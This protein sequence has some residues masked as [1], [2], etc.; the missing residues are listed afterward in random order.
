MKVYWHQRS[1]LAVLSKLIAVTA[2]APNVGMP[3]AD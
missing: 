3:L 1:K 2:H